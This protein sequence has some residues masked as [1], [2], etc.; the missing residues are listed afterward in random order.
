M[1]KVSCIIAAYN[2]EPRIANVLFAIENHPLI[3]EVIVVDDGSKDGTKDVAAKFANIHLIVMPQNKGKCTAIY[4]GIKNSKNEILLFLDA[5]LIGLTADNITALI[6]PV[7]SGEADISISMRKNS[8]AIDRFI[9]LDYLS[10]ERVFYKQLIMEKLE[11]IP[12][13][14]GFGLEVF[15]NRIIIRSKCRIKIIFWKNVESPWKYKKDGLWAGI[16][17]DI[18]MIY[19]IFKVIS[20]PEVVYQFAKMKS[21]MVE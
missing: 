6:N 20:P 19:Q 12:K 14:P 7:I 9:G 11:Q 3:D 1:I 21:R 10:G 17:G 18:K 15:L 16:K 2:E 13:L 8:P 4:T 5:D